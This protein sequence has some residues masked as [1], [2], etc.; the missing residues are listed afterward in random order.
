VGLIDNPGT[1]A[2]RY[3]DAILTRRL[4]PGTSIDIVQESRDLGIKPAQLKQAMQILVTMGL[5]ES[6][7]P[8]R[9]RVKSLNTQS[10]QDLDF[11]LTR[12]RL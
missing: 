1:L 5:V 7:G 9:V 6:A 12:R 8:G 10:L 2:A 11:T 3:R 4:S